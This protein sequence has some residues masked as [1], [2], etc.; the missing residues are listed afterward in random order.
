MP[1]TSTPFQKADPWA[2]RFWLL[3]CCLTVLLLTGGSLRAQSIDLAFNQS[4]VGFSRG[5]NAN[6]FVYPVVV[7]RDDKIL[8]EESQTS[9]NG[10]TVSCEVVG[11]GQRRVSFSPIYDGA[12]GEP[13][14]FS[15]VNEFAPTTATGPY[16][17]NL[18]TDNPV[19]TLNAQQG[20]SVASY[21][22]HW[23]AV[24]TPAARVGS[25][26]T[27]SGLSVRVLGNPIEGNTAEVEIR[28]ING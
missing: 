7:Q 14:S 20:S 8:V 16:S 15:V 6:G 13:I 9:N 3:L 22:Y 23:L 17:L 19:I 24:C 25:G 18:Y 5:D 4:A 11:A 26:E 2:N 28:G 12:N 10:A 27:S 21:T 1:Q